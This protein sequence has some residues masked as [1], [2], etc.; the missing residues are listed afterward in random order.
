MT[1][2]QTI[3]IHIR[4]PEGDYCTGA[5]E[6]DADCPHYDLEAYA[7]RVFWQEVLGFDRRRTIKCDSCRGA[8]YP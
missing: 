7:C 2:F 6:A 8:G 1:E 5:T 4:V 3:Q